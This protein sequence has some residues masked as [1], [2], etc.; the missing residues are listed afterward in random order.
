MEKFFCSWDIPN[1]YLK[2][3]VPVYDDSKSITE[4]N[5]EQIK[6][7]MTIGNNKPVES[8]SFIAWF[9]DY[10]PSIYSL[11]VCPW[12]HTHVC[13]FGTWTPCRKLAANPPMQG[14]LCRRLNQRSHLQHWATEPSSRR[15][16]KECHFSSEIITWFRNPKGICDIFSPFLTQQLSLPHASSQS[17]SW[18]E[19]REGKERRFQNALS[20][21]SH[22][23]YH[24]SLF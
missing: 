23:M 4:Q 6:C 21:P 1:D 22:D 16:P 18:Q 19:V 17:S 13:V 24:G 7:P 2:L 9:E 20:L 11:C 12:T 14:F 3:I 15:L 8:C 10:F 5:D